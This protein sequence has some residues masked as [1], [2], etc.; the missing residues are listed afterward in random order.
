MILTFYFCFLLFLGA[1]AQPEERVT[2]YYDLINEKRD[3]R[4]ILND[5]GSFYYFLNAKSHCCMASGTYTYSKPSLIIC[6]DELWMLLHRYEDGYRYEM[7]RIKWECDTFRLSPKGLFS[8]SHSHWNQPSAFVPSDNAWA[9]DWME[10]YALRYQL[11]Q[12]KNWENEVFDFDTSKDSLLGEKLLDS[13]DLDFFD[14]DFESAEVP[15]R[16]PGGMEF[17]NL[18]YAPD[19]SFKL[20]SIYGETC[21]AYCS[22]NFANYIHFPNGML[23][24]IDLMRAKDIYQLDSQLY[25]IISEGHWGGMMSGS[26]KRLDLL[27]R[28][29]DQLMPMEILV[30]EPLDSLLLIDHN[31]DP[32]ALW[33]SAYWFTG[34]AA[35]VSYDTA[36]KSISFQGDYS[37]GN[38]L[39]EDAYVFLPPDFDRNQEGVF[40]IIGSCKLEKNRLY[41]CSM[42]LKFIP[43]EEGDR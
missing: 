28:D 40:C 32:Q 22:G 33:M 39:E 35:E 9:E 14:W 6:Y 8:S 7:S 31:S 2:G 16:L 43:K 30:S 12:L 38:P 5:D 27:F 18:L 21:G 25:L 11:Y 19:S 4:L 17:Y 15:E 36:S 24:K 34:C 1:Q 23:R 3:L 20:F 42:N 29:Y 41:D 37:W 10:A 26:S 13:E